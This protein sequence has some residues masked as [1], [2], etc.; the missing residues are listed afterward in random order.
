MMTAQETTAET[1]AVVGFGRA[2]QAMVRY[3]HGSGISVLVSDVSTYSD[4]SPGEQHL[5][6][7]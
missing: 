3:L 6:N 5:L 7:S 1:M 2:G 4:L